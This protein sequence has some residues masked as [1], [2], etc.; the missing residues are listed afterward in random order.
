MIG[1]AVKHGQG[2]GDFNS[3]GMFA[4]EFMDLSLEKPDLH[5]PDSITHQFDSK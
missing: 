4:G 5:V 3:R 1:R 2:G